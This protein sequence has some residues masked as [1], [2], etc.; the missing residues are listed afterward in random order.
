VTR[1]VPASELA[2][3]GHVVANGS[4]GATADKHASADQAVSADK[5]ALAATANSG[6]VG[7]RRARLGH[8]DR[9]RLLVDV[10]AIGLATLLT[11]LSPQQ[12]VSTFPL[13]LYGVAV[14][15]LLASWHS[16]APRFP[17]D[18]FEDIRMS[19]TATAVAAMAMISVGAITAPEKTNADLWFQ[20]WGLS[21]IAL[22]VGRIGCTR[23]ILRQRRRGTRGAR[24]VIIGAGLVGRLTARRLLMHP[25][26]GL[27]PVGFLDKE[28]MEVNGQSMP[29]PV[30][31]ASWDIE[32]T[33][34]EHQIDCVVL[35]FSNAPHDVFLRVL[36]ECERLGVRSL[37][38]PRLFERVPSRF[39]ITHTGGLPLIEM[40]PTRPSSIQYTIK[41]VLDRIVAATML[42]LLAPLLV[43]IMAA[44]AVSLGRPILYRQK[45][46][47]RD[48][49]EFEMLKFRTMRPPSHEAEETLEF[50]GDNGPG[51]I[52]GVDRRTRV[53]TLLRRFSLDEFA[54]LFNVLRGEM[55][56]VGPRPE[57]PE[58]VEYFGEHVRRY[59]ARHRV[60]SGIT[61]WAQVH[62]LR[63]KTSISDRVEWDNYYI[64]NFSLWLDLKILVLTI[65]E[66][67]SGETE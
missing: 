62:R 16:Y 29:V 8:L 9:Q 35:T 58:F 48:G 14:I 31:G 1:S 30:L 39:A 12:S 6:R 2:T 21:C 46:V 11:A 60:K 54:Q 23:V 19:V 61:G 18:T 59:D 67:L 40:Y 3:T 56:L 36:D 26:F 22:V 44:V 55:S 41:N 37:V 5:A 4:N 24:T 50:A 49:R 7:A 17:L 34:R 43:V 47:G 51:G 13:F 53:S 27:R 38:V 25:E 33:V 65:P 63:G 15:V 10:A 28:P 45:R 66:V 32:S 64:E 52:E 42:L 57:R 20:L